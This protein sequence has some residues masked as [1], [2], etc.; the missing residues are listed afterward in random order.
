METKSD[1]KSATKKTAAKKTAAS[2]KGAK[3]TTQKKPRKTATKKETG[4]E[5]VAAAVVE[6]NPVPAPEEHVEAPVAVAETIES[7]N[8]GGETQEADFVL[9]KHYA[10]VARYDNVKLAKVVL[11]N[12]KCI[13]YE[14]D[15]TSREEALAMFVDAVKDTGVSDVKRLF[16]KTFG[17]TIM[18][19]SGV[20][21]NIEVENISTESVVY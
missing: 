2:T 3:K 18:V 21:N 19:E 14:C 11:N 16:K 1:K 17:E 5:V 9:L 15:A 6:T 20:I 4:K 12:L 13:I 7:G 8:L 10:F